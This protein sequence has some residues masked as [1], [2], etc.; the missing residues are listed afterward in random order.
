MRA[1]HDCL[2]PVGA[3][4]MEEQNGRRCCF[5]FGLLSSATPEARIKTRLSSLAQTRLTCPTRQ[6]AVAAVACTGFSACLGLGSPAG[7]RNLR[8]FLDDLPPV[9]L[10][11][12]PSVPTPAIPRLDPENAIAHEYLQA[13]RRRQSVTRKCCQRQSAPYARK[14]E[15]RHCGVVLRPRP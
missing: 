3:R 14:D 8:P 12:P 5:S 15:T 11:Q 7:P 4:H 1:V 9:G 6:P 13:P 10:C 2:A